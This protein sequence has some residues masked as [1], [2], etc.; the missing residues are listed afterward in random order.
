MSVE[1]AEASGDERVL[2]EALTKRVRDAELDSSERREAAE[3]V[4]EL[5]PELDAIEEVQSALQY[6]EESLTD[7]AELEAVREERIVFAES[8][9]DYELAAEVLERLYEASSSDDRLMVAERL[10]SLLRIDVGDET[11]ADRLLVSIAV[12]ERIGDGDVSRALNAAERLEDMDAWLSIVRAQQPEGLEGARL[13]K[14][15]QLEAREGERTK[16]SELYVQ[17]LSDERLLPLYVDEARAISED[18]GDRAQMRSY[19]WSLYQTSQSQSE[20]ELLRFLDTWYLEDGPLVDEAV[21]QLQ[22]ADASTLRSIG[23]SFIASPEGY[24]QAAWAYREITRRSPNNLDDSRTV[25]RLAGNSGNIELAYLHY[26]HI[27]AVRPTD[28]EAQRYLVQCGLTK[29][30]FERAL[31]ESEEA[32]IEVMAPHL[33]WYWELFAAI[34]EVLAEEGRD[35]ERGYGID[36][37]RDLLEATDPRVE[38]VA[39]ALE[40]FGLPSVE[41]YRWRGGGYRCVVQLGDVT[42]VLV[43]STLATDADEREL[44]AAAIY[45]AAMSFAGVDRTLGLETEALEV[46]LQGLAHAVVGE[47][48]LMTMSDE[49]LRRSGE[50]S[51]SMPGMI[52]SGLND[53][54]D[55]Y[56]K[57]HSALGLADV[58]SALRLRAL[59]FTLLATGGDCELTATAYLRLHDLDGWEL[60]D[61]HLLFEDNSE[62]K[63]LQDFHVSWEHS[64]LRR[65]LGLAFRQGDKD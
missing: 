52:L 9:N 60:E 39:H 37:E 4:R 45:S 63:R 15:A 1:L 57:R 12:R 43:G 38:T 26:R 10:E 47:Q 56:V 13:I 59:R 55:A 16:A 65:E 5:G 3:R 24:S 7:A 64:A 17:A 22:A 29:P 36:R 53:S 61:R 18:L 27:A 48:P 62:L 51:R 23:E 34:N 41:V 19:D 21:S 58:V 6:L 49:S 20:A 2:I 31:S 8:Q 40:W 44:Y 50:F 25:A 33:D 11:R 42:R 30:R 14:W 35:L 54:V 28:E 46:A 32:M